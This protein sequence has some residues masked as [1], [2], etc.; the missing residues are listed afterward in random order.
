MSQ[1]KNLLR[2]LFPSERPLTLVYSLLWLLALVSA[3]ISFYLNWEIRDF[4]QLITF[5]LAFFT[6]GLLFA[7]Y[8]DIH[9]FEN[10]DSAKGEYPFWANEP[11]ERLIRF[12]IV[13]FLLFAV[14]KIADGL[15]PLLQKLDPGVAIIRNEQVKGIRSSLGMQE[16]ADFFVFGSFLCFA[17][18]FI[19]NVGAIMRGFNAM[20]GQSRLTIIRIILFG[21]IT[22]FCSIYW[23][24]F[25]WAPTWVQHVSELIFLVYIVLVIFFFVLKLDPSLI[26]SSFTWAITQKNDKQES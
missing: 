6:T 7:V 13:F 11:E 24:L 23:A 3:M 21:L 17:F 8:Y 5:L 10:D 22:L 20:K 2:N 19:W 4:G 26:K 1:L 14:G 9:M 15:F 12:F 25:L 16:R 18:M